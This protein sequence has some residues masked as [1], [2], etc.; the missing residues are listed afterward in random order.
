MLKSSFFVIMLMVLLPH[1][2]FTQTR[3][4]SPSEIR[5]RE[6]EIREQMLQ[7]SKELGVA[8]T[9]CHITSNWRDGSKNSFKVAAE[10]LKLVELLKTKMDGKGKNLEANCFMCHRGQLRYQWKADSK[11]D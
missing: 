6:E 10:H 4:K 8:C 1:G 5:L 9:E 3:V 2:A 11:A 7:I